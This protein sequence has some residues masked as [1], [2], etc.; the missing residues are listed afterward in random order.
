MVVEDGDRILVPIIRLR[1]LINRLTE[2][3]A[4]TDPQ[5]MSGRGG[6]GGGGGRRG[7]GGGR[8]LDSRP[9]HSSPASDQSANR[10][11]RGGRGRGYGSPDAGGSRPASRRRIFRHCLLYHPLL[12][13]FRHWLLHHPLLLLLQRL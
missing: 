7:G 9:D 8:R 12:L 11:G 13:L 5:A 2:A 1:L 6:G 4:S 3:L 10:G